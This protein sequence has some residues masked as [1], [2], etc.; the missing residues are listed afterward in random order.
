MPIS[1]QT[2]I[3]VGIGECSERIDAADYAARS[4]VELAAEAARR[5]CDDALSTDKL[6]SQIDLVAGIRQFENSTP[7][8]TAPFGRS[9]NFPRSVAQRIGATPA[10]AVLE[11]A[12][13][14][15]PQHLVSE[16]CGRIAS[17][18]LR[19]ALLFGAEAISSQ[20]HLA[21]ASPRPNWREQVDSQLEDRGYGLR[22][23][24]S[25]YQQAHR[26]LSA[27]PAYGLLE[28]AR[29][30]RLGQSPEAYAKAMGELFAPMTQVAAQHPHSASSETWSAAQLISTSQSNRMIVSPYPRRLVSRDQVNQ[31]AALL[32]TCVGVAKRLGIAET[33]WIFLHGHADAREKELLERPDMGSY[34]AAVAACKQALKTAGIHLDQLSWLDFYSCFPVAVSS[35]LDGLGLSADDQR[36]FSLC[37]GLPY[38]G[39]AGNNYAM[40]AIVAAIRKLRAEPGTHALVGANGGFLSKYSVGVYSTTPRDWVAAD[41][42]GLQAELDAIPACPVV[43]DADGEATIETYTVMYEQG[44]P[45]F[46]IVVGQ[47][48]SGAGRFLCLTPESGPQILQRLLDEDPIGQRIHVKSLGYGNRFA[49]DHKQLRQ[50]FPPGPKILQDK[51]AHC[52][53]ERRGNLLEVTINRPAS[54]NSLHPPANEELGQIFDAFLADDSLWVAILTGAGDKAFCAGNDLMYQASG[55]SIYIPKNGFGGLTRRS[56]RNKPVIAAVNGAAMGGGFE[57]ALA[58]D[59]IVA[60]DT[61]QFAL[62]EV[63]VGLAAG[64]GGIVRLPRHIPRKLAMEMILTGKR[65]DAAEAQSLGLVNHIAPQAELM[66]AARALADKILQ[67]SPLAVQASMELFENSLDTGDDFAATRQPNKVFDKLMTSNDLFEGLAAFAEKRKPKWSGR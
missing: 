36:G 64:D 8:A 29:R 45:S 5:A 39:G 67:G 13:G 9:N 56:G 24:A 59:L 42:A 34:P 41:N 6:A 62:P 51:Y 32:L 55:K 7:M 50:L 3:L 1:D 43:Q 17:G 28:N 18:E 44:A 65:I 66:D 27:P 63:R 11:I 12:G 14:Q 54:R 30:G 49:F 10:Q 46:G 22:G 21:K 25:M 60:A 40:H 48:A 47:L 57:I 35:L 53:V 20:R 23:L 4:P 15:G 52:L 19:M 16:M 38:F 31:S 58:C 37:G 33:Q 26:L 61:A 2:P